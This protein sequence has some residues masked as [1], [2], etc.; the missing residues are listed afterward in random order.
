[1][2][3]L[4][5]TRAAL[6]AEIEAP[7]PS[8]SPI[9]DITDPEVVSGNAR[10]HL[11]GPTREG[12]FPLLK[13]ALSERFAAVPRPVLVRDLLMPLKHALGN[14]HK[15]GNGHDLV[16]VV[17]VEVVLTSS[18][19]LIAVTDEG[20]GFDVD[21]VVQRMHQQETYFDHH[22]SGFRGLHRARS[23]VSWENDGSTLLLCFRP[24]SSAADAPPDS[25]RGGDHRWDADRT[26]DPALAR[27]LDPAWIRT[28]LAG[29]LPE[30]RDGGATLESCH[31]Y[32]SR[33]LAGDDCGIRYVL[34]ITRPDV[35]HAETRIL[36]GRMHADQATAAADF[37]AATELHGGEGW[38]VQIPRP[39]ARLGAEQ[40]LVLY[41]FDPW[42]NLWQYLGYRG[43]LKAFRHSAERVGK[44][45]ATLHRSR[46]ALRLTEPELV[47]TRFQAMV[48]GVERGLQRLPGGSQLVDR[49][50]AGVRRMPDHAGVSG[51]GPRA[52]IHGA[53]GWDCIHYG[54]DGRFYFYRFEACRLSDPAIDL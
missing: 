4:S 10:V 30:F 7:D 35:A 26:D 47:G 39:V 38:K 9:H 28:C 34:Q 27:A 50:R 29:E 43:S 25:M 32:L 12:L 13:V 24:S 33:G 3:D 17:Q 6:L 51:L 11:R 14:A 42:M 22:G 48:M 46:P 18:G 20:D 2:I 40:R 8:G 45:L 21:L 52:P 36:T 44:A 54:V 23:P 41:D 31:S 19:A 53:L 37:E 5:R 16:K 1:M 15:H 49:F